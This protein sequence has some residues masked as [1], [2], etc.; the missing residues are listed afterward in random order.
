MLHSCFISIKTQCTWQCAGGLSSDLG[1]NECARK[2][3]Q[4]EASVP[5]HILNGLKFVGTIRLEIFQ[6]T[7]KF[8]SFIY[9]ISFI[10]FLCYWLCYGRL[11]YGW[12]SW[13]IW[14]IR[15]VEL[16]KF[17]LKIFMIWN[18]FNINIMS[19][20]GSIKITLYFYLSIDCTSTLISN[21]YCTNYFTSIF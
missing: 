4:E 1:V 5:D 13:H 16:S 20:S 9:L 7:M 2:E 18:N 8:R 11:I 17:Y 19:I 3:C 14:F 6:I 21:N 12:I 15:K 10:L